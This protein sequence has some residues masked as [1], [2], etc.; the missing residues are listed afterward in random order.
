MRSGAA[1]GYQRHLS[2]EKNDPRSHHESMQMH[3]QAGQWRIAKEALQIVGPGKA[4]QDDDGHEN[5]EPD[6]EA[7]VFNGSLKTWIHCHM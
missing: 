7:A 4:D 2:D 6:V 1:G 3:E 5:R